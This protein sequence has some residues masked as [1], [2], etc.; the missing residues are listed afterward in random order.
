MSR[1]ATP[2]AFKHAL[3]TRI[4]HHAARSSVDMGH[5]RQ[6]LVFDRFLARVFAELGERA[7][8]KGGVVLELRLERARATR[9]VDLWLAGNPEHVLEQLRKAA[10]RDLGD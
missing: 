7:V 9:D 4:R 3:E 1:Y 2:D 6:L 10:R 5:F 8:L